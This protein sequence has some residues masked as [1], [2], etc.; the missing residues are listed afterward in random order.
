MNKTIA[1]L[2]GFFFFALCP[3]IGLSQ[4]APHGD[5]NA[6][7]AERLVQQAQGLLTQARA[8]SGQI[9]APVFRQAAALL[10]AAVRLNPS[11]PRFPRLLAEVYGNLGDVDAELSAWGN[12]RR[13]LP[14]DRVAQSRVIE[15]Y[16]SRIETADGK[17]NYLKDLLTKPTLAPELKAH[18]AALAVPLLRQ[19]S[20]EEA[21]AMIH[22]AR[23]FYPLCEILWLEYGLLPK[24]ATDIQRLTALLDL[25]KANPLQPAPMFETAHFLTRAGLHTEA[26]H[27]YQDT[28]LLM[29]Q[30]GQGA[31]EELAVE[32]VANLYR[33]GQAQTAIQGAEELSG[34]RFYPESPEAW[35]LK[36]TLQHGSESPDVIR[37][38]RNVMDH[39]LSAVSK[40]IEADAAA[41]T[42]RADSQTQPTTQP[43][44]P[45]ATQASTPP[46]SQPSNQ[47][48]A[49]IAT[50]AKALDNPNA[51]S[52]LVSA[53]SDSAWLELYYANEPKRALP[54]IDGLKALLP[55][56]D[57]T[58]SRL[59]GWYDLQSGNID[60]ARQELSS[61]AEKDSLSL[62]GLYQ[63]EFKS[64]DKQKAAELGAKLLSQPD[65]GLLDAIVYQAVKDQGYTPAPRPLTDKAKALLAKFPM[66]WLGIAEPQKKGQP[67]PTAKFYTLRADPLKVAH[68]IG[69][70]LLA[71][72]T[73]TNVGQQDVPIGPG[74]AGVVQPDLWFDAQLRGVAQ[75]TFAGVAYDRIMGRTILRPHESVSQIV[76]ID[77]G[78]LASVLRKTPVGLL[79]VDA[80]VVL[81]PEL[82]Q[83][84]VRL[85]PGG[86]FIPFVRM[87]SR[88]SEPLTSETA[89]A[90]FFQ[91]MRD[92][93]PPDKL[94]DVD[95]MSAYVQAAALPNATQPE[96]DQ[97]QKYLLVIQDQRQDP[98][99]AV[100]SWAGAVAAEL[101]D[102]AARQKVIEQMA[103]SQNWQSRLLAL[104]ETRLLNSDQ[105]K[106]IAGRFAQSDADADVKS[107]AAA[108]LEAPATT[109][110]ATTAP[111][112]TQ[113]VRP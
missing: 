6:A 9:A 1:S 55:P 31:S 51:V 43:A 15:L 109:Q 26:T 110:P 83:D 64:G 71:K 96:K 76:R 3:A 100:A 5:A 95:V 58:L 85:G 39:A 30:L 52:S 79:I 62:L 60:Q 66:D 47:E 105:R 108:T 69:E 13:L 56:E 34:Q 104:L 21:N 54:F 42:Q 74:V 53:L 49:G 89:I 65:T 11:E 45:P 102:D 20:D 35:F 28:N 81:N 68:H 80:D 19:R 12:Y 50:K 90:K 46:A 22:Q 2:A 91:T 33:T 99:P 23:E 88:V 98:D 8:G 16:L 37:H 111:A 59:M 84:G 87:F 48:L 92:A 103:A 70:P 73:L 72:V 78:E 10:D 7:L 24:D 27:F 38:A 113:P 40:Q 63:L 106:E 82:S 4:A 25:L 97:A 94:R 29:L 107:F 41:T 86:I 44:T 14:D 101:L 112:A 61:V 67:L 18:I 36:L 93:S 57:V 77:Q 75:Q 32:T 17:I